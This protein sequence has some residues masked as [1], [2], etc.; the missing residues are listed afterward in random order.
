MGIVGTLMTATAA[1]L[2]TGPTLD[3]EVGLDLLAPSNPDTAEHWAAC[4]EERNRLR[5][6]RAGRKAKRW[7]RRGA[8]RRNRGS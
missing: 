4:R 3:V 6:Y 2:A 1:M 7:T 8:Q 5:V